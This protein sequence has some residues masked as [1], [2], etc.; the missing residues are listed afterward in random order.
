MNKKRLCAVLCST[1]LSIQS[2]SVLAEGDDTIPPEDKGGPDTQSYDYTGSYNGVLSASKTELNST[3][4]TVSA[5]K[6]DQN[7][8]LASNGYHWWKL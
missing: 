5:S 6:K 2:I 3:N 7:A 1:L 4:E 8:L